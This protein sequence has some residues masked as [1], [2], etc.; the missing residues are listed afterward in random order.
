MGGKSTTTQQST[1]QPWAPAQP[2]LNSILGKLQDYIPN[3]GLTT[4]TETAINQL[5]SNASNGNPYAP[6][7][8]GVVTNL[9]NGGG[10]TNQE[11]AI[12]NAYT[13]YLRQ[14]NPLASNTDY[15]PYN[16]PGFADAIKTATG[17]ITNQ[18]NG[19][20]AA[21]GRDLSGMNTQTLARGL[22]QGLAPTI[23]SQYNQNV[24]NQQNAAGNLYNAGNTTSGLLTGLTQQGLSNQ[25]QG[26]SSAN[27]ALTA[28]NYGPA[29]TLQLEQL[30]QQ[31]P[32]QN[33]GLLTQIGVPIAGLGTQ[34]QGTSTTTQP[35][36]QTFAQFAGG[37]G[38][39]FGGGKK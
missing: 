32:F 23:A 34:S 12:N 8:G 38:S 39:L 27:D 26:I 14:T 29:T 17:D 11:G 19:Q 2:A 30:K 7:I 9:L 21:A 18:I 28:Q 33:L 16:T 5:E 24:Q 4:G 15:N 35:W 22:T 10:A 6:Q 25:V 1:T 31:I 3:S 36:S 20:F 37:L 13:N